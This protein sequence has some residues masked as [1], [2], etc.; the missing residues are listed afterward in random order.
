MN[1]LKLTGLTLSACL[2]A[3][4]A[5]TP[6]SDPAAPAAPP[7]GN[8][9]KAAEANSQVAFVDIDS[10]TQVDTGWRAVAKINHNAPQPWGNSTFQSAR[11]TY[12]VDCGA[13]RLADR[14][15][16]IFA[17]PDLS[18]K[19]LSRASRNANNLIWRDVAAGTVE[20]QILLFACN[21]R[22]TP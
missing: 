3:A 5:S 21:H 15:N 10:I 19:Q 22:R 9:Q 4:C 8:W 17:G 18:G 16:L 6:S 1:V 13:S 14:E 11:N 20:G 2:L 12:I 7:P